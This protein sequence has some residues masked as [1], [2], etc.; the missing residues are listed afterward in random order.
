MAKELHAHLRNEGPQ[1]TLDLH[2]THFWNCLPREITPG[3][4][5]A[6]VVALQ[7]VSLIRCVAKT[8]LNASKNQQLCLLY[9]YT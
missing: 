7:P 1:G 4:T 2:L 6:H 3:L 9:S 8:R 5:H